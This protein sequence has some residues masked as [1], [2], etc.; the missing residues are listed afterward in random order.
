MCE[1]DESIWKNYMT[2]NNRTICKMICTLAPLVVEDNRCRLEN[3]L[4]SPLVDGNN[5]VSMACHVIDFLEILS[6]KILRRWIQ[7]FLWPFSQYT[8]NSPVRQSKIRSG[9]RG[10]ERPRQQRWRIW[11]QYPCSRP[12]RFGGLKSLLKFPWH[13][14]R[15]LSCNLEF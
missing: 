10:W 3:N 1:S 5:D 11:I 13:L 6:R 14:C 8:C 12:H 4:Q 2:G 9:Q 7:G 15:A